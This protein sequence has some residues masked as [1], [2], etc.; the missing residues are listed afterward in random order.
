MCLEASFWKKAFSYGADPCFS[1]AIG[2]LGDDLGNDTVTGRFGNSAVKGHV[3][4]E[5][6]VKVVGGQPLVLDQAPQLLKL[7][8]QCPPGSE[9]CGLGF[10]NPP[11]FK[12]LRDQVRIG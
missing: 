3:D 5:R 10:Y 1:Q 7:G 4:F 8:Y 6:T 11:E 9:R 2:E 12:Q